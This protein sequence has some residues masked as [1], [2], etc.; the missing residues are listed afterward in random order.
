MSNPYANEPA[1]P[2]PVDGTMF[3]GM[4]YRQLL[5][6]MAMQGF[7]AADHTFDAPNFKI[8]EWAIQQADTIIRKIEENE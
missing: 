5:I 8:A 4:T 2:V 1:F 6:G 7:L 3:R